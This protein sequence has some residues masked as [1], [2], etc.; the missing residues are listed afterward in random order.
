[1]AILKLENEALQ[2][3]TRALCVG[4]ELQSTADGELA[5]DV[6]EVDLDGP[7]A[8]EETLADRSIAQAAGDHADDF[9]LA[10]GEDLGDFD[11]FYLP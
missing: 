1:M 8:D 5:E 4:G 6:V 9:E 11:G 3:Q 2:P 10:R 7:L